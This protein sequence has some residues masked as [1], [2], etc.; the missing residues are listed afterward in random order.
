[1]TTL[2]TDAASAAATEHARPRRLFITG[3]AGYVGRNLTRFFPGEGVTVI[4]LVRTAEA[5]GRLRAAG[6]TPVIGDLF[7]DTLTEMMAGCDALIHAA[8]DTDHGHGGA[9]QM[10]TNGEGTARVFEAARKAGVARAVHVSTESVLGDGRPLRMVT[11]AT[12][13]P[14]RPAGSYSRSKIAAERNALARNGEGLDVMVV[15]PRLV[16]GRDDTTA[17]PQLVAA[18]RSGQMAWIDGGGYRTST[19]HI[20]N[21]IHG[22]DLALRRGRGGEVYF[23]SDGEPMAFRTFISALLETQGVPVPEKTVPR[24]VVRTVAALGDL[25]GAVTGGR[26]PMPLTL[27]GFAASAVEVTVDIRK[28]G[29]TLGY[30]PL[31][32]VAEGLDALRRSHDRP[33]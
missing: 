17:L 26:K 25:V 24:R 7:S 21:L 10:R 2:P 18:A 33:G 1:M 4:A 32:T 20:D 12:P 29:E 11:E 5:A 15:R 28:A 22:I 16:W 13:Y 14:R 23:L 27:Q 8:A 31:V 3:A 30:A 9:G 19:T 6:V